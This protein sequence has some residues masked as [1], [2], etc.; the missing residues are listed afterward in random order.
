MNL[1]DFES[2][3][4]I[5]EKPSLLLHY[6]AE[7]QRVQK[8][9][10]IF[11]DE[12]DFLGCYLETGLNLGDLQEQKLSLTLTGMS[13]SIDRYYD[14]NDAGVLVSKPKPKLAPYIASLVNAIEAKAFPGWTTITTDLLRSGTY[15]EQRRLEKLMSELKTKVERNWRDPK[16]QCSLCV[17]SHALLGTIVVFFVYPPQ[18]VER[19]NEIAEELASQIFDS[20]DCDRCVMI[21]R[22]TSRWNEPY[23]SVLIFS[24]A[25]DGSGFGGIT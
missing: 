10:H 15:E 1:A 18:L 12:M 11:A 14:N 7:R 4:E 23:A 22:N 24:R 17:G 21:C 6:F 2:V 25:K 20:R 5:L 3:I 13:K 8:D 9:G 16:H 19:R